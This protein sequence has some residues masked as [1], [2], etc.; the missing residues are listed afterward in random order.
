MKTRTINLFLLPAMIAGLVLILAGQATAQT[1]RTIYNFSPMVPV[2]GGTN[3]DG[4]IPNG[5]ILSGNVFYGTA[6]LGGKWGDGSLWAVSTD[7]ADAP[8][9]YSFTPMEPNFGGTNGDGGFPE[10]TLVSSGDT[11]YGTTPL[12]G[13]TGNGTLFAIR[14]DGTHFTVLHTFS[15][16]SGSSATNVDGS[17]PQGGLVLSGD[18]LFGTAEW[19]G[20]NGN[21]TVWAVNTDGSNFTT[22]HHFAANY[23]S[24]ATNS[25]GI[26][27]QGGMVL[28]GDTLFGTAQDGGTNA[29]GTV[30]AVTTNGTAFAILHTFSI[31]SGPVGTNGDGQFPNGALILA[32]DTLYGTAYYGGDSGGNGT[33]FKL[34]T[35]GSEFATLHSFSPGTYI[36]S[37]V[38]TNSDGGLPYAG[39]TLAGNTLFGMTELGGKFGNGVV[40]AVGTNGMGFATIHNFSA[41][42][43]PLFANADG[44]HPQQSLILSGNNLYGATE[45]GGIHGNGAIFSISLPAPQLVLTASASNLILAWPTNYAGFDDSGYTLQFTTNLSPANWTTVSPSPVVVNGQFTV[46]NPISGTQMFFRLSQP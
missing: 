16:T 12:G 27:P 36:P 13:A 24:P 14:T 19:G 31:V 43:Y 6:R 41:T 10:S 32:G 46:T 44:T 38:S 11:L 22:L 37:G 4:T 20:T 39:V 29:N 33:V 42:Q 15:A 2:A 30:W 7:S 25:D 23:G 3:A 34:N 18:T 40:F 17:E 8:N 5:L 35:N 21:G 26:E 45:G 1:F 28:S 9:F